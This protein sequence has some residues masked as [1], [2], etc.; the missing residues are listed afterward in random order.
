[1][2]TRF[3]RNLVTF[4]IA[5][6]CVVTAWSPRLAVAQNVDWMSTEEASR[7]DV[8]IP[9]LVPSW[10]PAPFGGSPAIQASSGYY[11]LYWMNGGGAP[12]F[13]HITGEA[14]GSLPA[15]SPADLNNQLFINA[16]V[17]GYEAIHD[18]TS[19]YD[20]VWWIA[21]G[22]LYT[23]SSNNMTGADSLSLANSLIALD[24]PVY[25]PPTEVPTEEPTEV[26]TEVATEVPTQGA[27]ETPTDV[28]TEAP[29]E[30]A[31]EAPAPTP[32]QGVVDDGTGGSQVSVPTQDATE[33][34][35][36][37]PAN[38]TPTQAA[39]AFADGTGGSE[40]PD[41]L[42]IVVPTAPAGVSQS[43]QSGGTNGVLLSDGTAGAQLPPGS[44]GTG[45]IRQIVLP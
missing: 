13:L 42:D 39:A 21:G 22:V 15:G 2:G 41:D 43:P 8:G 1:M 14:G 40:L 7:L 10:V 34:A 17:Q 35:S 29:T 18:V 12:T 11:S 16:S 32:T 24:V 26:A 5:A 45:G 31:T 28:A 6:L 30:N 27:T 4:A 3:L 23:V 33:T 20:N 38:P 37:P 19:I 36:E 9:V 25:V 44:D